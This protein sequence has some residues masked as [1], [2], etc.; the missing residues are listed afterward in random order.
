MGGG[1]R[2]VLLMLA[3]DSQ[4]A[5]LLGADRLEHCAPGLDHWSIEANG[6]TSHQLQ[7]QGLGPAKFRPDGL[8][9]S[10]LI[11][12]SG[13]NGKPRMIGFYRGVMR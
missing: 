7:P 11:V 1:T 3:P 5:M 12:Y 6:R 4:P 13:F 8:A 2:E 10:S 9:P